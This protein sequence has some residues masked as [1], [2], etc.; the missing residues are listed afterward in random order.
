[1]TESDAGKRS[2]LTAWRD[3]PRTPLGLIVTILAGVT[4]LLVAG[5]ILV[6]LILSGLRRDT[7]EAMLE[8]EAAL[9]TL[10]EAQ[11]Q[12]RPGWVRSD[13]PDVQPLGWGFLLVDLAM[14]ETE[15]GTTV[16]GSV[17]N[18]TALDHYDATFRILLTD[19]Y[20][21]EFVLDTLESGA[22]D[23]FEVTIPDTG[24]VSIPDEVRVIYLGS[25]VGYY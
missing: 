11:E 3:I 12:A 19:A 8:T 21:G 5:M 22:S 25:E 13:F 24:G 15:G 4:L 20:T 16:T 6:I 23:S 7:S 10:T 14:E 2:R 9:A 1:M 18:S 17:I